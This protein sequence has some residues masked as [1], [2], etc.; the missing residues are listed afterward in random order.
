MTWAMVASL[1]I[2]YGPEVADFIV[3]KW[4]AKGVVTIEEWASLKVL[5]DKTPES[6]LK[7]ALTRNGIPE[8]APQAQALLKML[9]AP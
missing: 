1:L 3:K 2:K 7:D 4:N 8:D 6:Q 5:A 9:A